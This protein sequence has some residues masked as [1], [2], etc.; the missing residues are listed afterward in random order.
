MSSHGGGRRPATGWAAAAILLG[1]CGGA[2]GGVPQP[3]STVDG[4]GDGTDGRDASVPT[5]GAL[6]AGA[7]S[8][9]AAASASDPGAGAGDAGAGESGS[10]DGGAAGPYPPLAFASI[11]APVKVSGPAFQFTEGPVWD[12]LH[13]VLYL[14]DINA[15]IIYRFTPPATFDVLLQPMGNADGLA[16][17]PQGELIAAGFVSRDVWKLAGGAMQAL[18][19]NDQGKKLDSPDDLIARSDGVIYFTDPTFGIS[20]GQGFAAQTQEPSTQGVYRLATDGSLHLEDASTAGPNG[21][22]L[23]PD[24]RTLYVS[25]TNTGEID[26]FSVASDG[27]LGQKRV[28]AAGVPIADSMCVDAAGDVY[29]ATGSLAGG[30]GIAVFD[31]AGKRLGTIGLAQ[32]P[33][34]CAFGGADQRTLFV[35]ARTALAGTPAPGNAS[36]YRIDA[37]PIPGLP[38]RP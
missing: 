10:R 15:D 7:R 13:Q 29:A 28:F 2:S 37:M 12:P 38:G 23:S 27:A 20:G 36:L 14:T 25:Y 8:D 35:T 30:G 34:N 11:G 22:E 4:T 24:E 5:D 18:A 1:A 21:V 16:L 32:I 33:T 17:T 26:A 9:G 6:S 3:G 31:P 19:S